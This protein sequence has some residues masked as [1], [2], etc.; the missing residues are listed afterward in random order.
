M[1]IDI[2]VDGVIT[3]IITVLGILLIDFLFPNAYAENLPFTINDIETSGII[4]LIVL[5]VVLVLIFYGDKI[6]SI[7]KK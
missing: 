1:V 4:F 3:L 5:T 2:I 6:R 7:I